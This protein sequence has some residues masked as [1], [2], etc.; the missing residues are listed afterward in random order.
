[1][2]LVQCQEC[3]RTISDKAALCPGCGAPATASVPPPAAPSQ[4]RSVTFTPLAIAATA[5]AVPLGI[6]IVALAIIG[7]PKSEQQRL[8]ERALA[9]LHKQVASDIQLTADPKEFYVYRS[10]GYFYA[11]GEATLN[12][13]G[14]GP[15]AIDNETM[16]VV[17]TMN[18]NGGG[19]ALFNGG[20]DAQRQEFAREE[21][22]KCRHQ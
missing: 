15:L 4:V 11:C 7:N 18:K 1:M 5:I 2:A 13:P 12:R 19:R 6:V 16:R 3:S 21:S 14:A 17:V 20:T 22:A 8:T 10:K 9:I